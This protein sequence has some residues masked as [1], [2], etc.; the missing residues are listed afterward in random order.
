MLIALCSSG[1]LKS[2]LC[3]RAKVVCG[4]E[5]HLQEVLSLGDR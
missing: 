4:M 5:V 3:S 2:A 1:R